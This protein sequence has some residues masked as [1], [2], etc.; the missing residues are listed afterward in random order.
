MCFILMW[1]CFSF[2]MSDYTIIRSAGELHAGDHISVPTKTCAGMFQHHAIV[3]APLGGNWFQIIHVTEYDPVRRVKS[4]SSGSS[5]S[6]KS[7]D[8]YCVLE[9]TRDYTDEMENGK[10]RRYE[11]APSECNQPVEVVMNGREKKDQLFNFKLLSNN[12]E[13]FARWCKTGNR[14]SYQADK[15]LTS[16]GSGSSF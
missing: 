11:Y 8:S 12:C 2:R 5:G 9:E 14:K 3:V 15:V 13:H 10:L 1:F 16:G 4:S 7:A 6:G